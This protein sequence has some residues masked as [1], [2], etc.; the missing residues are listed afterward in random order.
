ME[1]RTENADD[2]A[3]SDDPSVVDLSDDSN[4]KNDEMEDEEELD[5]HSQSLTADKHQIFERVP[6]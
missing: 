6:R 2:V 1:G 5:M 3:N 4:N